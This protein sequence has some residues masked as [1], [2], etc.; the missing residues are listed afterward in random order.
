MEDPAPK[1]IERNGH[2]YE[3]KD[4]KPQCAPDCTCCGCR[5]AWNPAETT[6]CLTTLKIMLGLGLMA[7]FMYGPI[8]KIAESQQ[9]VNECRELPGQP[10]ED[11]LK[12]GVA[13]I[14]AAWF[15]MM[16][17]AFTVSVLIIT[18]IC[19]YWSCDGWECLNCEPNDQFCQVLCRVLVY[20]IWLA[21]LWVSIFCITCKSHG[22]DDDVTDPMS[23]DYCASGDSGF[24]WGAIFSCIV[25]IFPF[26][27]MFMKCQ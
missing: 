16:F 13:E 23:Y 17:L 5:F 10:R 9:D 14:Y 4:N 25:N 7:L 12:N 21:L 19:G 1:I 11:C 18:R 27:G 3:R 24:V 26:V 6:V 15:C 20:F 22:C 8:V 2:V